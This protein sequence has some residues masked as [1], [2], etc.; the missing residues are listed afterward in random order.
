MPL[1]FAAITPHSPV[2]IPQIGKDNRSKAQKTVEA[3][4]TL[5]ENLYISKPHVIVIFTAHAQAHPDTFVVNAD[6]NFASSFEEFGDHSLQNEYYGS[7]DFAAKLSHAAS[8]EN[9]PLRLISER[10]LDH[11]CSVPLYYLTSHLPQIK[12]V[13]IGP[14]DLPPTVHLSFG[15]LIKEVCMD[16]DKRVALIASANLSHGITT[17]SP[18]GFREYGQK[19]DKS[20]IELL[21]SHNTTGIATLDPE[22][23]KDAA[24]TGYTSILLLL[25][26]L[27]NINYEFKHLA[28]EAPF[29][30]G[31]LTGEFIFS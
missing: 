5:E 26:A 12:V 15:T 21:Q 29:G 7:P 8:R 4:S 24:E 20:V 10:H 1:V 22:L 30:V 28:Y 18:A 23:V 25:G 2:L 17:D 31:Y 16:T 14:C 27:K 3:F 19:F 13:P 6:T 9:I 11:G